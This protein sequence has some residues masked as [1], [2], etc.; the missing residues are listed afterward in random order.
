M[1]GVLVRRREDTEPQ[2]R[3][4]GRIPQ[5]DGGR[6]WCDESIGKGTPRTTSSNQRQGRGKE[7]SSPR[8]F[9]ESMDLL[10]P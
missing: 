1:A 6:D 9:K 4:T 2:E 8:A 10:T 5:E 3:H 7:R